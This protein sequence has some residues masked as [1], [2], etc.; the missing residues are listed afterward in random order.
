VLVTALL[1]TETRAGMLTIAWGAEAVV[2]FLAALWI[3]ERSYRLT[4]LALLLLCVGKIFVF[5]FWSLS[6]RD[7]ALTGMIVGAAL[8]GVSILYARK[9]EAILQFL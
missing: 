6:L 4:G 9:R 3:G 7:K 8:I 2:V 1:A 5:D